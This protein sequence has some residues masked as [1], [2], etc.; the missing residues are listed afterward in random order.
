MSQR[1]PFISRMIFCVTAFISLFIVYGR[2]LSFFFYQ[3]DFILLEFVDQKNL[4]D[5]IL[6]SFTKPTRLL[7]LNFGVVFR[8]L[9]H[10]V[11]FQ[12][13][14]QLFDLNPISYRFVNVFIHL[15]CGILVAKYAERIGG[16]PNLGFIAGLFFVINRIYFEP[17]YWI[18]ANNE[19]FLTFFV[20]VS[21]LSFLL[22]LDRGRFAWFYSGISYGSLLF[23]L[24]SKETA[25]VTPILI[26]ASVL[27]RIDRRSVEY[28]LRKVIKLWFH[29]V[30]VAIFM[31]IRAPFILYALSGGGESY[32]KAP[33]NFTRLMTSYLWG[34]WW[35]LETFVEPWRTILNS[36]T[37]TFSVFQPILLSIIGLVLVFAI[38]IYMIIMKDKSN[39]AHLVGL[40]LFWFFIS[41]L[42]SL[43][44]GVLAAY[45]FSLPGVGFAIIGS[46]LV[47]W[48]VTRLSRKWPIT[49][50]L[51]AVLFLGTSV[52][53][54]S[55]VV[56]YLEKTAWPAKFIPIVEATVQVVKQKLLHQPM[57]KTICLVDFPDEV[58]WPER[59]QA[60][61][62]MF[63]DQEINVFEFKGGFNPQS[64][65]ADSIQI[66]YVNNTVVAVWP[67][68]N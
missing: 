18:S 24:L 20:L 49:R 52:I 53:S 13:M 8:P 62:H 29:V 48:L 40:G 42:P 66:R 51:L 1:W 27:L 36:L 57:I 59:A 65:P 28:K 46:C 63:I 56:Q 25:T 39:Y 6:I 64:C 16:K 3:D 4:I 35:A 15:L 60:A 19:L 37:R 32:Y 33:S 34:F 31:A 54:A 23:A 12:V 30:L 17:L 45:L 58:W 55:L 2:S 41:A 5:Y 7:P 21:T 61:F 10:Y 43:A 9:S 26:A 44:T 67:P 38:T 22:A 14:Y 68:E 47:D 11:Y 50:K